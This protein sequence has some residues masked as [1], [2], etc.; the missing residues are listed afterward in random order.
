MPWWSSWGGSVCSR[1]QRFAD[2]PFTPIPETLAY[3]LVP[4][5]QPVSLPTITLRNTW[6]R[7]PR[8]PV[9]RK[10]MERYATFWRNH[11]NYRKLVGQEEAAQEAFRLS[12]DLL[13]KLGGEAAS[14]P[15]DRSREHPQRD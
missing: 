10:V 13:R 14:P 15:P 7:V 6:E 9:A 8:D 4:D 2:R 11:G 1:K 12:E 3:R 5:N